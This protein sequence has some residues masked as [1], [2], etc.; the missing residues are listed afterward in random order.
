MTAYQLQQAKMTDAVQTARLLVKE[1]GL[2]VTTACIRAAS[3]FGL[4]YNA[5]VNSYIWG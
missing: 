1:Y 4:S 2:D 3:D 5:V